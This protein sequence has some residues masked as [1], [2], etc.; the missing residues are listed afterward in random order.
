VSPRAPGR[1]RL[2]AAAAALLAGLWGA[3]VAAPHWRGDLSPLDRLEAP[4]ADLRFLIGGERPAPDG[5]IIVA[6]DDETVRAAGAYPLP[7]AALARLV[8]RVGRARPKAIA[9][10]LLLADPGAGDGDAAL[11]DALRR[12]PVVLAAAATFSGPLQSPRGDASAGLDAVPVADDLLQPLGRFADVAAVGTVNVATDRT[13]TPRHLPLILRWGDGLAM[14]LPLRTAASALGQDPVLETDAVRLG[15]LRI[16]TDRG[17]RLPLRFYGA[18]GTV[19]TVSAARVLAGDVAD[20]AWADRVVLV[21]A[22]VTGGGDVY[23]SPFDPVMPGV[24]VL[25]TATA[26]LVTGDG[27][28][29]NRHVRAVDAL[30]AVSLP[31]L[32]VL[33]LAWHRSGAGF[34]LIAAAVLVWI[35]VTVVA[36]LNGV[37][38]SASVPLVAAV[39]PAIVFGAARLWADRRRADSLATERGTLRRFQPPGLAE[40]LARDPDF[41]REPVRQHAAVVFVDLSGFTGLSESLGP[42]DT[43]AVL[44]AFHGLVDEEA[45]RCGGLVAT[46]MGDGAMILFGLPDPADAD[47]CH[48]VEACVGLCART[49][50]WL[51]ALPAPIA[52]RRLGFK[53]GAHYG[54]IVASRL[55]GGS[56]EHITAIGD[57]VNVASRLM[58]VAAAHGADVA[59]SDALYAAAGAACEAFAAG[60]LT[61][62]VNVP[63]RG[64]AGALSVWLWRGDTSATRLAPTGS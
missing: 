37:W 56:H 51:A 33:L 13:G 62:R 16:A 17:Y 34:A 11:A 30:V 23:P 19:R 29:R 63:I 10:D 41:L 35:A 59:V 49:S 45:V 32:L 27:L 8:E 31:V 42:N 58:T 9:L 47:P 14:S 48:A 50:A 53:I 18:R 2:A 4:L 60:T 1:Q 44:K 61:R 25:A 20:G 15:G 28:V 40:R 55:G 46:F 7:R 54:P 26:H 3:S 57:T 22:T 6:V 43:Q 52:A 21:G 64:R 24:E 38:L 36:F 5:V 12:V 39:P